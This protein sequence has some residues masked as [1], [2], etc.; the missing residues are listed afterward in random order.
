MMV[1]TKTF[2]LPNLNKILIRCSSRT[3]NCELAYHVF[4][5][6]ILACNPVFEFEDEPETGLGFSD[7]VLIPKTGNVPRP[8]VIK[9]AYLETK[10]KKS[11]DR[12]F[13]DKL[14]HVNSRQYGLS[15]LPNHEN[16]LVN[17]LNEFDE[18]RRKNLSFH[19]KWY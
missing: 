2:V 12:L 18:R 1:V 7:I 17:E 8:I 3:F 16:Y 4:L 9:I 14:D 15:L 5:L 11:I 6:V 13:Q 19:I 10:N